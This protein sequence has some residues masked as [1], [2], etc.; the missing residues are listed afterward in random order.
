VKRVIAGAA[1]VAGFVGLGMAA[2]AQAAPLLP[3]C[4]KDTPGMCIPQ[5]PGQSALK[6]LQGNLSIKG[7]QANLQKNLDANTAV[8]NL[9]KNLSL[10]G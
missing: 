2:P 9:Q 3:P 7:A 1:L 10:G 4:G 6:N 5:N 8:K